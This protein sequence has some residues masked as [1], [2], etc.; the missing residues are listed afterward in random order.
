MYSL[1]KREGGKVYSTTCPAEFL[2]A[3]PWWRMLY[4]VLKK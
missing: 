2:L 3:F 1:R 4:T